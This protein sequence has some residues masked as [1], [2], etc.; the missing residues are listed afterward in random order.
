MNSLND[1]NLLF[2]KDVERGTA[3]KPISNC[4]I[5]D[6]IYNPSNAKKEEDIYIPLDWLKEGCVL[7]IDSKKTSWFVRMKCY[8]NKWYL[9]IWS[10]PYNTDSS[11]IDRK[12]VCS[13]RETKSFI[14][15]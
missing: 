10:I 8:F 5:N 7:T 2:V 9:D 6:K 13:H 15:M 11:G 1:F 12:E 3:V 14:M 4:R